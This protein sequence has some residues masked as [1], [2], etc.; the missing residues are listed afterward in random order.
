VQCE[1]KDVSRRELGRQ[2]HMTEHALNTWVHRTRRKVRGFWK[3][4]Q[5][6]T[7]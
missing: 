7:R 3:K 6:E 4:I 5:K 1:A 2:H